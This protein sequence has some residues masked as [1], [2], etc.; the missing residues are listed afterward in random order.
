MYGGGLASVFHGAVLPCCTMKQESLQPGSGGAVRPPH[1]LRRDLFVGAGLFM[2]AAVVGMVYVST[3][4][5]T[6]DFLQS[7]FGPAALFA[8]GKGFV[9]PVKGQCPSLDAFLHPELGSQGPPRIDAFSCDDLPQDLATTGLDFFQQTTLYMVAAAAAFWTLFGV[10]WSSLA[11]L[12]GA[13]YGLSALAF[14]GFFRLVSKWILSAVFTLILIFSPLQLHYLPRLRDYAK[15]PFV[16]LALLVLLWLCRRP[17]PRRVLALG[18]ALAGVLMGLSIGFRPETIILIPIIGFVFVIGCGETGK[19]RLL[20]LALFLAVFLGS[21]YLSAA[22]ILL[23]FKGQAERCHPF[24]MGLAELYDQRLGVGNDTYQVA[25]RFLDTEAQALLN[26]HYQQSGGAGPPISLESFE[27]ARVGDD[28][29]KRYL[30]T[31]PADLCVRTYAAAIKLLDETHAERGNYL[32]RGVTN[33]FAGV[34]F[35]GRGWVADLLLRYTRYLVLAALLL[36]ACRNLRLAFA[37]TF[38]LLALAG[39]AA[40]QFATR[41]FFHFEFLGLLALAFLWSAG[42]QAP[43]TLLP[44][45]K[46]RSGWGPLARGMVFLLVV[47]LS[48][49]GLLQGLRWWQSARVAALLSIWDA[50][51]EA[52][53]PLPGT[54]GLGRGQPLRIAAEGLPLSEAFKTAA[55]QAG[56]WYD[57]WVVDLPAGA[58]GTRVKI[59]VLYEGDIPDRAPSW[60]REIGLSPKGT[61]RLAFPVYSAVWEDGAKTWTRFDGLEL[62]TSAD[63]DAPRISHVSDAGK[64]PLGLSVSLAPDW[65][66]GSLY[67]TLR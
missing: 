15:A 27:Y 52:L 4:G 3:W 22:P 55:G 64:Y 48:T 23:K 28:Y 47:G 53:R 34:L 16:L 40:V 5:Q 2:L 31:F 9:N 21:F 33:R 12:F 44:G 62:S 66:A 25:H 51:A 10:A 59:R 29:F 39:Q 58:A 35:Q 61:T 63:L 65:R 19:R 43:K 6:A 41:H 46:T 18:G 26:I 54:A 38:L 45:L 30:W 57:Y 13:L 67:Q 7:S 17:H 60:E 11:P 50:G 36:V 56:F 1:G 37:L 20:A 14:Y 49:S 32:P 42:W 24:L 8:C